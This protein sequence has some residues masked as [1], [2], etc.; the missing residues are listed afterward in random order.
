[1][2]ALQGSRDLPTLFEE[3]HTDV[4][5]FLVPVFFIGFLIFVVYSTLQLNVVSCYVCVE[6]RGKIEC[7]SASGRTKELAADAAVTV[8]CSGISSGV[9]ESIACTNAP[10]VR[11]DCS[12]R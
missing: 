10:R 7:A 8:A 3:R 11:E 9:T 1:M 5:K 4:K 2:A 12:K 6:Y